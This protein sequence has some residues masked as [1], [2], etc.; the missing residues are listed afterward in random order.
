MNVT[1]ILC[2]VMLLA[3]LL[4]C[5]HEQ[6]NKVGLMS[7]G[8]LEGK[9]IPEINNTLIVTG[10]DCGGQYYLSNAVRNALKD[11]DFDTLLNS[12]VTNTTGLF[13]FSNCITVKGTPFNSKTLSIAGGKQ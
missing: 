12:E 4:G 1:R 9:A 10:Q 11:T 6:V 2:T 3:S 8:N 5:G 7:F 13:V